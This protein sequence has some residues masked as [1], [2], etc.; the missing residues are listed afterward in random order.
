MSNR[1]QRNIGNLDPFLEV[2]GKDLCIQDAVLWQPKVEN[3]AH[4]I[5]EYFGA[6]AQQQNLDLTEGN[7][8]AKASARF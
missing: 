3:E 4:L 2:F 6:A 7:I 1:F 8:D 5:F